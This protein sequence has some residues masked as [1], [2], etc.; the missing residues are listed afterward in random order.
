MRARAHPRGSVR[1]PRVH[2]AVRVYVYAC[3]CLCMYSLIP[4]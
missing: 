2:R 3:T 4:G 1:S